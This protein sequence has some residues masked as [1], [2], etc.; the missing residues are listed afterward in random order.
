MDDNTAEEYI[1][2]LFTVCCVHH[3]EV[4]AQSPLFSHHLKMA[5][6]KALHEV[7]TD[8][9]IVEVV[10]ASQFY[11]KLSKQDNK[12]EA[13]IKKLVPSTTLGHYQYWVNGKKSKPS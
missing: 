4:W 5:M 8:F 6:E 13:K 9:F 3:E 12:Y 1:R 2:F 11:I 7:V 10:K